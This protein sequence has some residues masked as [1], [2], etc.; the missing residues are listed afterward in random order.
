MIT[1]DYK[2]KVNE[3]YYGEKRKYLFSRGTPYFDK[4]IGNW[5][6][7]YSSYTKF[8]ARYTLISGTKINLYIQSN[9]M[10]Q[11][12]NIIDADSLIFYTSFNK[13]DKPEKTFE[14]CKVL[15]D[16]FLEHI[17]KLTRST[18]YVLYLTVGHSFR[19]EVLPEYK[20]NRKKDGLPENFHR[21]KDYLVTDYKAR[22]YHTLES[23]DLCVISKKYYQNKYPDAEVF[24]SS[25]DKDLCQL[26]GKAFNYRSNKW[27]ES[28]ERE[29]EISFWS[30]M[31][32]GQPGDNVKGLPNHGPK[33]AEKLFKGTSVQDLP[34]VVFNKYIDLMGPKEGIQSY[35][36][37]YTV[38]SLIDTHTEFENSIQEPFKVPDYDKK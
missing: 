15:T 31:I 5:E 38:L 3:F 37:N 10:N 12:I 11:R 16:K 29:S 22:Y 26:P 1:S 35:Y 18:H 19:K 32:S 8:G 36:R 34:K 9:K 33:A 30:D 2:F 14:E 13:K 28:T 23:D 21:I 24:I 25:P 20:A 17:F 6:K 27:I 7:N 4:L